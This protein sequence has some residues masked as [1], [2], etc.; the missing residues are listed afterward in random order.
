MRSI[1]AVPCL[2]LASCTF[3]PALPT[4]G[5]DGNINRDRDA[6][7][8]R[9]AGADPDRD[10]GPVPD[11]GP[12]RDAG[13][14]RDGGDPPGNQAPEIA[15]LDATQFPFDSIVLPAATDIDGDV[16]TYM[17]RVELPNGATGGF[18]DW[19]GTATTST[20]ATPTLHVSVPGEYAVSVDVSDGELNA[21]DTATFQVVGFEVITIANP[22]EVET[23]TVDPVD[24]T[25]W[26]GTTGKGV[27]RYV[28]GA[29]QAEDI[30]CAPQ[31]KTNAIALLD[32][33]ND[34][35]FGSDSGITIFD[36]TECTPVAATGEKPRGIAPIPGSADFFLCGDPSVHLFDVSMNQ[37][38]TTIDFEV[39]PPGSKYRG[40]AYDGAGRF[41]FGLD[42]NAPEDGVV[43]SPFPLDATSP[44]VD[45]F[46]G[47]ND[48]VKAI[49]RAA[50]AE[51]WIAGDPGVAWIRD[52]T[53]ATTTT[54]IFVAGTDFDVGFDGHFRD[55]AI[56]PNGDVWFA[57]QRGAARY[58]RA[59][60]V[61]VVMPR[62][63]FG[64]PKA[65]DLRGAAAW[66]DTAGNRVVYVGGKPDLYVLRV[67]G[68]GP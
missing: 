56:V 31:S 54:R 57:N 18:G 4:G 52:T 53:S 15:V 43:G 10:G 51:L 60:D 6:G 3:D 40:A 7:M 13:D 22:D 26:I 2:V 36:G 25:L 55:A 24:G 58:K 62:G 12:G 66:R 21:T 33:T 48:K 46:P 39:M 8:E 47:E 32:E 67:P 65:A 35:A 20:L 59:Q 11:A 38:V 5:P 64:L 42:E 1:F 50:D 63:G 49:R 27:R 61:F 19:P 29:M 45:L 16:L 68:F 41:W 23:L 44:R 17:W 28:P 30:P 14:F 9:D 37:I 34:V